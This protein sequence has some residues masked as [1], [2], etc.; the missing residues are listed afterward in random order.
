[1]DPRD[2]SD[3]YGARMERTPEWLRDGWVPVALSAAAVIEVAVAYDDHPAGE[4]ALLSVLLPMALVTVGRRRSPVAVALAA[5]VLTVVLCVAVLGSLVEQPP[6]TPF[7]V[8][9][10]CLFNLGLRDDRRRHAVGALAVAVGLGGL[11]VASLVAGQPP[12]DVVPSVIF[13][14]G[15][16]VVGRVVRASRTEAVAERA[17]ASDLERSRDEH[18]EAA[19]AFERERLARELHDI[20]AHALTGIVVQASVEARLH[21]EGETT[22]TLRLIETRGREAMV[23]LRRLLGLLREDGQGPASRPLPSLAAVDALADTLREAGHEVSVERIGDL[24]GLPPSID[25]A[26]HRVVQESL[27]N[28]ARHAPGA[29]VRVRLEHGDTALL[30]EVVNGPAARPSPGLGAGGHGLLGME[31]R[32]R[33]YGGRLTTGPVPDGGFRVVA[34]IPLPVVAGEPS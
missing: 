24:T 2:G 26:G 13:L 3:D 14:T 27:T 12:G 10:V 28:V 31:E 4:A 8:L 22:P 25:L 20:V 11:Q 16:Y 29:T 5:T 18:A 15:A 21:P 23:E 17:R 32:V 6:L 19:V 1:M 33:V 30:L 7:L 9:L 34:E